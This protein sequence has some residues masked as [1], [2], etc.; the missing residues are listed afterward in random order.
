MG[1][2][3]WINL[4]IYTMDMKDTILTDAGI[5]IEEGI[6]SQLGSSDEI[7]KL[8]ASKGIV[9][10]AGKGKVLFPGIINTHTHLYQELLKGRGADMSL[11][12]WWPKAMAPAG[13]KL[14]RRHVRAGALLGIAEA[15]QSGV[16][17][18]GDYMQIQ[19]VESLGLEQ[20]SAVRDAGIRMVYG[21]GYRDS[22]KEI[23]APD[24]LFENLDKVFSDVENLKNNILPDDLIDIWLAP[25]AAWG[26]TL[27]SLKESASYSR[28]TD[29]PIMM[30]MF[31]TNMDDIIC[32]ER[33][34]MSAIEYFEESGLLDTNLLAVHSVAVDDLILERY[35]EHNVKVSY[36]PVSNMYLASGAAPIGEM[37]KQ[38]V[39]I[40][41]GTDGA[42]SNNDNDMIS[43]LKMGALL[44]K[45]SQKDPLAVTAYQMMKMATI[46]GA[47]CLN[48]ENKVG[49]IEVGKE[50]DLFIFNPALSPK[51]YPCID[52]VISL[53]YSGDCKAVETVMVKGRV[54]YNRS[55]YQTIDYEK[56]ISEA[57]NM[58]KE[59]N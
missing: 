13:L 11:I 59:L 53:V 56:V 25:A 40:G 46:D 8:A 18:I 16:T 51:T 29:T 9:C 6:I 2:S 1:N 5:L 58:A 49:S 43:A 10:Q 28:N 31:E 41:L 35:K 3:A 50:A 15:L 26:L 22:G 14:R 20:L 21:R 27:E 19:P 42:G 24:A 36:N 39:V 57:G 32:N 23:G 7:Q 34:Q 55:E 30:H 45:V 17:T 48:L 4:D 38:K 12:D 52:P 33:Y 37:L 47:R 44:Q 54:L